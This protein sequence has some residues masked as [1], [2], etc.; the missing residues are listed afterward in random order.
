M[1]KRPCYTM[2]QLFQ[3]GSSDIPGFFPQRKG[4]IKVLQPSFRVSRLAVNPLP[5]W[6]NQTDWSDMEWTWWL[7]P[8]KALPTPVRGLLVASLL[9]ATSSNA[10]GSPLKIA[11]IRTIL[12]RLKDSN[13]HSLQ[14]SEGRRAW[15][16][17]SLLKAQRMNLRRP[18][19]REMKNT[20]GTVP[21]RTVE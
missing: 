3:L 21:V 18:S 4:L 2:S 9:L 17:P 20:T 14:G 11:S 6:S 15:T 8:Q 13:H 7:T 10:L 1:N 19:V 16:L 12:L 5:V